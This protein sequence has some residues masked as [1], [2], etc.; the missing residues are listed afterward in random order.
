MPKTFA[1]IKAAFEREERA[2]A[3]PR[4]ALDLPFTYEAI[5]PR[6]LTAVLGGDRSGAAVVSHRL[7]PPDNGTSSRRRIYLEW[8]DRGKAAGFRRRCSARARR[9]SRA[10]TCSA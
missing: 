4:T 6:W 7:G 10:A 8:N 9:P 5:T 3:E 1:E 2:R